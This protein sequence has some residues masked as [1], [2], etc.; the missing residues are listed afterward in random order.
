MANRVRFHPQRHT[1]LAM[2]SLALPSPT[3][4]KD[5]QANEVA[6]LMDAV[7]YDKL[8]WV[9]ESSKPSPDYS[10]LHCPYVAVTL[11]TVC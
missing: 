6:N 7:K 3:E 11:P 8:G 10:T 9:A 5:I 4:L 1:G 2:A